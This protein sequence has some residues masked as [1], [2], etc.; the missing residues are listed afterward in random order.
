MRRLFK[1]LVMGILLVMI[2]VGVVPDTAAQDGD[3]RQI[4]VT[5]VLPDSVLSPDGM[6]LAVFEWG[7]VHNDEV[8]ED[9]LPIQLVDLETGDVTRLT[10][11]TDYATGAAFSPDGATLAT[12]HG[13]G[14]LWLW[15]VATGAVIKKIPALP[16]AAKLVYLS[17]GNLV[18]QPGI[19]PPS[20][21]VW[22]TATEVVVRVEAHRY[23]S[24]QAYRES[25]TGVP[26]GLSAVAVMPDGGLL[27]VSYRSKFWL[28]PLNGEPP[29]LV[30]D[31]DID[32]PL[33][34]IRALHVTPDG[35]TVAYYDRDDEQLHWL[36]IATG[37]ETLAVPADIISEPGFSADASRAVWVTSDGQ[38]M[39]WD[40]AQPDSP[41]PITLP[42]L[43]ADSRAV[44]RE[45]KV[46]L[47]PE[48]QVVL[49]G[50]HSPDT[51][52]NAVVIVDLP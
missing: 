40:A 47:T 52:E 15:D 5:N 11:P 26:D 23:A 38:L 16:G 13:G 10:G 17:D 12:Y 22:D 31:S 49:A 33:F 19:Q 6:T 35:A 36:D 9:Y 1:A 32:L 8:I 7:V 20:L 18:M 4:P 43:S 21:F 51:G 45:V 39:L 42:G 50:F 24:W 3:V 2:V 34:D 46:Y 14:Y 25:S 44:Y 27:S 28:W 37:Q 29:Q 30:R 48:N 41:T